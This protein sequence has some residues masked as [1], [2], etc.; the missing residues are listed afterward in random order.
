MPPSTD[1]VSNVKKKPQTII[2]DLSKKEYFGPN[3]GFKKLHR[4]LKGQHKIQM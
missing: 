3:S 1:D 4:K 2:F